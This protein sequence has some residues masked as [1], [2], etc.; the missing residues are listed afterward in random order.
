MLFFGQALLEQTGSKEM[1][2]IHVS[3]TLT[4][5]INVIIFWPVI[6]KPL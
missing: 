6:N 1:W 3:Y 5:L 4:Y 2:N